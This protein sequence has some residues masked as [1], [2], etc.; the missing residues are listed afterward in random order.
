[1]QMPVKERRRVFISQK[2]K[3]A[4]KVCLAALESHIIQRG[5]TQPFATDRALK[6]NVMQKNARQVKRFSPALHHKMTLLGSYRARH[7]Y[8]GIILSINGRRRA[9]NIQ[10]G[11]QRQRHGPQFSLD[12]HFRIEMI[13]SCEIHLLE[14]PSLTK[15]SPARIAPQHICRHGKRRRRCIGIKVQITDRCFTNCQ[16]RNMQMDAAGCQTR[17]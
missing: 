10:R 7:S 8:F 1:M 17:Q 2:M 12:R 14:G 3:H 15:D 11:G 13:T 6:R 4:I 9:F 16:T 5:F